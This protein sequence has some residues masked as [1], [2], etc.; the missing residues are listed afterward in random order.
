VAHVQI[1][2]LDN[3]GLADVVVCDALRDT[4]GWI[5]Q[6]P[7]G[8]FTETTIAAIAAPAHAT[9]IDFDGDGD[10]DLVIASLGVLMP[11]NNRLGAVIVLENDGHQHFM[12]HVL[13]NHIPR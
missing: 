3:G 12:P 5:R 8:V 2:D 4:V 10:V 9:P 11:S 13:A 7:K 1:A 6:S